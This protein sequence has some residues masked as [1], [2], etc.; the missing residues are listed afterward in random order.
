VCVGVLRVQYEYMN[1]IQ[2]RKVTKKIDVY[3]IQ[4]TY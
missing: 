4:K 1:A 2:E 3:L